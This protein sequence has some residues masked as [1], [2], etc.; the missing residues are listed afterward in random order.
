MSMK[1]IPT[2][3]YHLG[4]N[5]HGA[6]YKLKLVK[7]EYALISKRNSLMKFESMKKAYEDKEGKT[8]T[9]KWCIKHQKDCLENYDLNME[10][11]SLLDHDEFNKEINGFLNHYPMFNQIKDLNELNEKTGY[12][13]LIQD[14][15]C[16]VYIG[17]S[18]NILK[19]IKEHWVRRKAFDRLLMPM[20][21]VETSVM[22]I[23]SFRALDT[24]RVLAYETPNIFYEEDDYINFF[25]PQFI[26]N[27]LAGGY[28]E[29]GL[30][31]AISMM[32]SRNLKK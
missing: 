3:A 16:Q 5:V 6:K 1:R 32:K 12:Y 27:R 19:R 8:Y 31:E 25:S 17:T 20:G 22:S 28:V 9:D 4:I 18:K 26:T 29:G 24:T 10:F 15:Y 11:F 2:R 7:E 23:D 21:A 13:I 30:I 14:E